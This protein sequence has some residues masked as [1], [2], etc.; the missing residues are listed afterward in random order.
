MNKHNF[1]KYILF[2]LLAIGITGC[3]DDTLQEITK[4]ETDRMFSPTGLSAIVINKTGVRLTWKEVPNASSY[5]I[6]FFENKDFSGT[7]ARTVAD[8]AYVQL[9]YTV[10]N[11]SGDTEYSIRVKA[12]GGGITDSKWITTTVKTDPE[13]IFH[14][15]DLANI[16]S[17]SVILTWPAGEIATSI[18][19]SPGNITHQVT[20]AEVAAGKA[21]VN[22]LSSETTYTA[23]LLNQTKVRGLTTFSTP[24]DLGGAIAVSTDDNLAELIANAKAGDVFALMPGNYVINAD[25]TISKTISLKGAK[26]ADKPVLKGTVFRIKGNAGL[27]IKDVVLDGTGALNNNQ[28]FIFDE[29]SDNAY[30][31]FLVE[32]SEIKNYV[33]GMVY[34]NVKTLIESF[35]FKGNTISNVECNGGDFIDF[36]QGI[37]KTVD[38]VNNTVYNTALARDFFRMDAG[39]STNFPSVTAVFTVASNTFNAVCNS[40]SARIFYVRVAKQELYFSKNIVA[41]SAGIIA[42]QA[43]TI[44]VAANFKENNYH[45]AP[46]YMAGSTAS[47]PKYDTGTFTTLDPGFVSVSTGNFTVTN[48]ELKAKGIGAP[49]WR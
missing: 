11:L 13:Q 20:P 2:L 28:T 35:S 15:V 19:L 40:A 16:T 23:Q 22:G 34:V 47:T 1:T 17:N 18:Q 4:M 45:N 43:T 10:S 36:R 48:D 39:G 31:A 6:E 41:N 8:V 3:K 30:G 44:I 24:L 5:V 25:I 7:P 12:V 9:P 49:K 26:P 32:D 46:T 42:N 38:F 27:T 21:Q 29:A 14:Q 33:K 37:A